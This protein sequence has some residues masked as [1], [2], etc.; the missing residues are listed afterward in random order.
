[1]RMFFSTNALRASF[2][3]CLCIFSFPTFVSASCERSFAQLLESRFEDPLFTRLLNLGWDREVVVRMFRENS[4]LLS[5]YRTYNDEALEPTTLYRG[6]NITRPEEF[7]RFG[8]PDAPDVYYICTASSLMAALNFS[9][10]AKW[11][12]RFSYFVLRIQ[13]PTIEATLNRISML[14][15]LLDPRLYSDLSIVTVSVGMVDARLN[16]PRNAE[17]T[18]AQLSNQMTWIPY[19]TLFDSVGNLR[20]S[21][22][23]VP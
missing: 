17:P 21:P 23:D 12:D 9:P 4:R 3:L 18:K 15:Y 14:K 8:R 13:I 1:M 16:D 19:D 2:F 20:I 5:T 7:S 10:N 6:V 22:H 11:G